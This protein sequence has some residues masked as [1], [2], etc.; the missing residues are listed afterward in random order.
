MPTKPRRLSFG[1]TIGVIAPASAP[2]DPKAIDR[3]LAV[4][5]QLGFKPKLAPNVRKRWGFLAGRTWPV[6]LILAGGLDPG[7]VGRAID[8]VRPS[9]VDVASGVESSP[10][11]KDAEK[12][13]LFF[14]AVRTADTL[15][16]SPP[17]RG[18]G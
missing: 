7:N 13:R 16:P 14:E 11:V 6:P 12:M 2:P 17:G 4:L 9:A 15:S 5:E 18:P 3:S 8:R 1:D 10:G